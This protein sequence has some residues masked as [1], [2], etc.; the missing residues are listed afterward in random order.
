MTAK[1]TARQQSLVD[2]YGQMQA[3]L[4]SLQYQQQQWQSIYSYSG[5]A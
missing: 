5:T 3:Q 2:Q 1:L 4:Y